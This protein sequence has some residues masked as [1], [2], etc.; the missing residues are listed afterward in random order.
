MSRRDSGPPGL[1]VGE[2]RPP[3]EPA[4]VE[5]VVSS[6]SS[7]SPTP[8]TAKKQKPARV[9]CITNRRQCGDDTLA[10]L[11]RRLVS[12]RLPPIG[13][14]GCIRDPQHDRH[15]CGDQITDR[16]LQGAVDAAHHIL[17][18]GYLPIFDVPTLRELWKSGHHQLVDEL[19]GGDL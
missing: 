2:G 7:P 12:R 11:H 10:A 9:D 5:K 6:H 8:T 18:A 13:T 3:G 19:R 15:R 17:E 1:E 4:N 14:C 16:Q